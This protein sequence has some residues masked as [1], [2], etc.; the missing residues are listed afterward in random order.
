VKAVSREPV[1]TPE[2]T[3]TTAVK[4]VPVPGFTA[5]RREVVVDH[6]VVKQ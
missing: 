6:A 5:H 4:P 2:D 1:F 3:V